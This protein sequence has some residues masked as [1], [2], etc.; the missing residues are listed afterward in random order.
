ME[1]IRI[2]AVYSS[3]ITYHMHR[4]KLQGWAEAFLFQ[5]GEHGTDHLLPGF[6]AEV[7]LAGSRERMNASA[8]SRGMGRA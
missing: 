2:R 8:S 5:A 4:K 6:Y 7:Y 1:Y 3:E